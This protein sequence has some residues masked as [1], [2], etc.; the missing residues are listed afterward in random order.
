[1]L[2]TL[3]VNIHEFMKWDWMQIEPYFQH[4]A[5]QPV[6]GTTVEGWL[7]DWTQ[8]SNLLREMHQRLYVASTVDTTD[9]EAQQRYANFLDNI[10]PH[11][12]AAEQKLREILL[13]SELEPGGFEVPLRNMRAEAELFCEA[14]L[15]LLSEE[16][17]L[18]TEHDRIIGLQ[19]V[20]WQGKEVTVAQLQ[21][22]YQNPDRSLR[23]QAW[24]LAA[25][26]QLADRQAINDLWVK[27]L[28]IRRQLAANADL[29][30]YR[31]FRWR[32]LL[33]FDYTP[34]DCKQFHQAIE[35]EVVPVARRLYDRRRRLLGVDRLR[36][37]DLVV[38]VHGRPAL[39]P[40]ATIAEL[41]EKTASIFDRVNP[42][43]GEYF[44]IMRREGLLDLDNRKGKAPGGYCTDFPASKRP[45]IFCNSVGVHDDVQT[46][47]HEGGHAFHVF[48]STRLPYAQQLQ[49]P[50]EFAEVASM[51]MEF[52][53][54]PYLAAEQGGFY[55][56]E[57]AAQ[58]RVEHLELSLLFWP[59]MAVV[60]A[61]QH[62]V[63]EQPKAA[64][65]PDHCDEKWVE[66]WER[67]M[68][69]VDWSGLEQEK[70]TGW[71][72]KL[73][74]HEDPFYYVEY[75]LALLGAVQVWRNAQVDQDGA[76]AAYRRALSLG[77]SATLPQLFAAAGAKFA[78]DAGILGE[79]VHLME[80][81]ILTL[82]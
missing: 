80:E 59:Y 38:D 74:I 49:V 23:E 28:G 24:K 15:P 61:F 56:S 4:L 22:I 7:K 48:E 40:F 64:S 20:E 5:Y 72:R 33:R 9:P 62:W 47:I 16:L 81:T 19:T 67:F 52:L 51:G 31:T 10:F 37:W 53:A 66:L 82:E 44:K 43:L 8:L 1:M 13:A 65:Q 12:Q 6:D 21:P 57:G 68:V 76:T 73:H 79:A 42:E 41:E 14:N 55:T 3:A 26:R 78:F 58:A 27:L 69:G 35:E 63:Y 32:Q 17:K 30:D 34:Q 60:D 39:K 70:M 75:G 50:L 36:P 2:K 54:S 29:P 77:G 45:F 11:A 18:A 25:A 46:L 71:Q